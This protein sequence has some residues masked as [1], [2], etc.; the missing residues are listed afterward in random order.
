MARVAALEHRFGC[1]RFQ[2]VDDDLR[3]VPPI[4]YRC[5]R[6]EYMIVSP[7]GSKTGLNA[8]SPRS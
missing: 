5:R 7:S 4:D 6:S 2:R 3:P 1:A 8:A